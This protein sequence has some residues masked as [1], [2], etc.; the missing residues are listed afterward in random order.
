M[1]GKATATRGSRSGAGGEIG[2][3]S[4]FAPPDTPGDR[5]PFEI[6]GYR[7]SS[8]INHGSFGAVHRAVQE[9]LDRVVALKVIGGEAGETIDLESLLFEAQCLARVSHPAVLP[10]FDSGRVGERVFM[11]CEYVE[12]GTLSEE[13]RRDGPLPVARFYEV[14]RALAGGLAA[15]HSAGILHRDLKPSNVLIRGSGEPLL[16]D[17]GLARL[18]GGSSDA[19]EGFLVGTPAYMA[20]EIILGQPASVTTD[21]YALC[22]MFYMML[23]G[24]LPFE[25]TDKYSLFAAHLREEPVDPRTWVPSIP[26]HLVRIVMRGLAKHP[27]QRWKSARTLLEQLGTSE[28]RLTAP[29]PSA[30]TPQRPRRLTTKRLNARSQTL[31]A[32]PVMGGESRRISIAGDVSVVTFLIAVLAGLLAGML[33]FFRF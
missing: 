28:V 12:G 16:C 6:P 19:M 22:A 8:E 9:S 21:V 1:T 14:A 25:Q 33:G 7:I 18:S 27:D 11:A 24:H 13:I 26:S 17:F 30:P 29:I 32:H 10:V 31:R 4:A 5:I 15:A 20:P 3:S 23:T 2:A